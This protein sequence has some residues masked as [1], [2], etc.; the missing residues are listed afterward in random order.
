[1]ASLADLEATA[2]QPS[3]E[4]EDDSGTD[5]ESQDIQTSIF[6]LAKCRN[7]LRVLA[8]K[9]LI[10]SVTK[11]ERDRISWLAEEVNTFVTEL[12]CNYNDEEEEEG[13]F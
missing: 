4:D 13:E 1:M 5:Y 2:V 10:K 3:N 12:E 7:L 9:D 8:D 11:K 6:W